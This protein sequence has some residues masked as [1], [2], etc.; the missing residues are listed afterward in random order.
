MGGG[1]GYTGQ[2]VPQCALARRDVSFTRCIR[3]SL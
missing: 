2:V 1:G 3:M